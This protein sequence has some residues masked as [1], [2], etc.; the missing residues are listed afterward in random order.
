M[1]SGNVHFLEHMNK[2]SRVT[3]WLQHGIAWLQLYVEIVVDSDVTRFL[4]FPSVK[5]K[6]ALRFMVFHYPTFFSTYIF[7]AAHQ[8]YSK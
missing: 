6:L 7:L 4:L 8:M 1:L 2:S 5:K 3:A